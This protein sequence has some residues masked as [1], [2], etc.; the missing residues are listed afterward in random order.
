MDYRFLNDGIKDSG[1]PAP[2]LLQCLDAAA[3]STY[4]SSIDFNSGYHQIPCAERCK[5]LLAFSPAYGF[6]TQF[7]LHTDNR[8]NTFIQSK[9][10]PN[11]WKLLNWALKL[12]EVDYKI[13]HIP[14][15]NN[16]INDCL[17]RLYSVNVVSEFTP[18]FSTDELTHLQANDPDI[19]AAKD[20]LSTCK[21]AFSI[22]WLGS[23]QKYRNKLTLSSTGLLLWKNRLVIPKA[24]H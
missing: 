21:K 20:Y 15:K 24:L 6:G 2:S 11:S 1:W 22:S 8:S 23:L 13:Q 10:E 12:S 3:G 9:S 19:C 16:G 14:S 7:L 18:Q 17:S 5:P 4:I